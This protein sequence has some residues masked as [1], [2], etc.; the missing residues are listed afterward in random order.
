MK[1]GL[2][3]IAGKSYYFDLDE[4][5]DFIRIDSE[6]TV[7][8]I[9]NEM[10]LPEDDIEGEIEAMPTAMHGQMV[11][12][13]K[14][15]MTKAMVESILQENNVVDER[16]GTTKLGEQLSIPFRLS[17]NTLYINKMIKEL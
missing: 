13:T 6:D 10:S 1:N 5:S 8:D 16:M 12:V 3:S 7:D 17:F 9:L 14:W 2:F 11:D 15:E 4:M